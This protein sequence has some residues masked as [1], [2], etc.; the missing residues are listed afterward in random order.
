MHFQSQPKSSLSS[1]TVKQLRRQNQGKCK[2]M[3]VRVKAKV[4]VKHRRHTLQRKSRILS[5]LLLR[6][7]LRRMVC[8]QALIKTGRLKPFLSDLTPCALATICKT[9]TKSSTQGLTEM[10]K[11]KRTKTTSTKVQRTMKVNKS[12][13]VQRAIM[14]VK[15]CYLMLT[16]HLEKRLSSFLV[17]KLN[18]KPLQMS[19]SESTNTM[20][21][22]GHIQTTKRSTYLTPQ[23]P[24]ITNQNLLMVPMMKSKHS[25][26]N[27]A[28]QHLKTPQMLLLNLLAAS[29]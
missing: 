8:V 6:K 10:M 22:T 15:K 7:N 4:K 17:A 14:K 20:V 12:T 26:R 2:M 25:L 11:S 3:K 19:L 29:Q 9:V 24:H 1:T 5:A 27:S 16:P 18:S 13:K 21:C 28:L 23:Q